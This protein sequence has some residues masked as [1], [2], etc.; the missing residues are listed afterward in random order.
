MNN[1]LAILVA[2]VIGAGIGYFVGKSGIEYK[3]EVEYKRAPEYKVH[4]NI[5]A[6][7]VELLTEADFKFSDT[8][9]PAGFNFPD[10]VTEK[11]L[12]QTAYDWNMERK[13]LETLFDNQYGK[14]SFEAVVKNNRLQSITP[15]FVPIEKVVTIYSVDRWQPFVMA[16]YSSLGRVSVGGGMFYR[17]IGVS[18]G[19]TT[20]FKR[21]GFDVGI[22]Y[23]F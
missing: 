10:S 8:L 20:D 3:T 1:I 19:Y 6:P 21:K 5:P 23:K 15:S 14:F 9:I 7:K 11:D 18:A 12:K 16:S 17:N 13:Y 22:V 4:F 2:L